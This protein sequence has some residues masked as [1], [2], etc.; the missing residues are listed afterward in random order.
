MRPGLPARLTAAQQYLNLRLSPLCQGAGGLRPGGLTW[1]FDL[2]PT[3][4]SRVYRLRIEYQQGGTPQVFVVAPDLVELAGGRKLPH[5]YEQKPTRLCL[6]RP[7]RSE[8][9]PGLLISQTVVQWAALWLFFFEEW[10]V[11]DEWAGGG[12]HPPATKPQ[13]G[14]RRPRRGRTPRSENKR[15]VP[16][17]A[18]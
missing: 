1:I 9:H 6:Y 4:L 12:E 11:S 13:R 14:E 5:V 17:E 8:W 2:R 18:A 15:I 10:L 7:A 16:G 3:A